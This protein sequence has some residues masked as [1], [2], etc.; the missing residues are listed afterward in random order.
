MRRYLFLAMALCLPAC[1]TVPRQTLPPPRPAP[2]PPP[3]PTP[4]PLAPLSA[5][6][7]DWPL[8]PGTW[9]LKREDTGSVAL[10]GQAD[11][12]FMVRCVV[13]AK[14][15]ILSRAGTLPNTTNAVMTVRATDTMK[16]YPAASNSSLPAYISATVAATDPQLDAIAFSRGRFMVSTT[17]AKDLVI[18]A[19][20]EFARVVED[21]RS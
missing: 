10:F 15:V 12:D 5:N 21:C 6:W 13:S 17:G 4:A 7:Q 20:P 1:T 18:P 16:I 8:S 11:A 19:W 2:L 9:T 14:T 3:A